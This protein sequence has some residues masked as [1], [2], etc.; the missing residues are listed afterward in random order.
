LNRTLLAACF[1]AALSAGAVAGRFLFP[2]TSSES[3]AAPKLERRARDQE[4]SARDRGRHPRTEAD[5]PKPE[6]A[7]GRPDGRTAPADDAGTRSPAQADDC[8]RCEPAAPQACPAPPTPTCPPPSQDGCAACAERASALDRQVQ[9][10]T[11]KLQEQ[12]ADEVR[13][14]GFKGATAADRR[15][16]AAR[17][18]Q[19]LLEMPEWGDDYTLSDSAAEKYGLTVEE[20]SGLE[21]LYGQFRDQQLAELRKLYAELVGDPSA[22][23]DQTLNA[24]IH[25]VMELSPR[26]ACRD[27]QL[28]AMAILAA[29]QS[30][31]EPQADAPAC[32]WAIYLLYSAVDTLEAEALAKYGEKGKAALWSGTSTFRFSS[33]SD[34]AP[35]P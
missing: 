15:A 21:A 22:G 6:A 11:R 9:E 18:G 4:A 26:E 1:V 28:A 29:G 13:H 12:A 35:Q 25:Q 32:E 20:R 34:K 8:P 17:Q 14:D 2:A 7:P 24:L 33:Q 31:P 27:R 5:A 10:L 30:L 3:G 23:A 19:T 16:E